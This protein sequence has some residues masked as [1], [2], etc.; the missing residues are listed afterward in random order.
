MTM[1]LVETITVGSGGAASIEFTGIAGDLG[2]DLKVV[3]S[4]RADTS[5]V[6]QNTR[7]YFNGREVNTYKY[8]YLTGNG[9]SVTGSAGGDYSFAGRMNG[10]NSTAN[11]F[12]NAEAYIPNYANTGTVT[13]SIESVAENNATEGLVFMGAQ[14]ETTG[15]PLTNIKIQPS[16]GNLVEH[17]SASLYSIS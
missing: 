6:V 2:K 11:T 1:T 7:L 5:N 10:A 4:A 16:S 17:S 8:A 12:C 15:G 3:F 9:S 14:N 13:S